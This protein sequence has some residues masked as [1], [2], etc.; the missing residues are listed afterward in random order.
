VSGTVEAAGVADAEAVLL[1]TDVFSDLLRG[2]DRA[3]AWL[4]LVAGRYA[5]VSFVTAGELKAW[6]EIRNWGQTRRDDLANRLEATVVV[7]YD[8]ALID[9]YAEFTATPSATATHWAGR[10][11]LTIAGS[12]RQLG[13]SRCRSS[14]ATAGISGSP[15]GSV[16]R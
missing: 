13:F 11:K 1:D 6:A 15:A 10:A 14:R 16:G 3:A 4:P 12:Q 8:S 7:P 5:L 2:G 9:E